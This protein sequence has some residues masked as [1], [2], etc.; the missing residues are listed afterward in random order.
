MKNLGGILIWIRLVMLGTVVHS[1][2]PNT[3]KIYYHNLKSRE[4]IIEIYVVNIHLNIQDLMPLC[5]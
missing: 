4:D 2:L 3:E 5:V 1:L